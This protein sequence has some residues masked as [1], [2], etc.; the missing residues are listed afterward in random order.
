MSNCF[1]QEWNPGSRSEG[2]RKWDGEGG[3][4]ETSVIYL[5]GQ[6]LV[7]STTDCLTSR[8][9]NLYRVWKVKNGCLPQWGAD[10]TL[11]VSRDFRCL[12]SLVGREGLGGTGLWCRR[13]ERRCCG[14]VLL[15][16]QEPPA[17]AEA[18]CRQPE[19]TASIGRIV[20]YC[21]RRL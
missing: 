21:V 6:H 10:S 15:G 3:R 11:Q 13:R 17:T 12:D 7:S 8:M 4:A 5:T 1:S 2:K 19:P 18:G 20:C 9:D 16:D 14:F